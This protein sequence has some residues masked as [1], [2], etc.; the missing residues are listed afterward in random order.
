MFRK[1]NCLAGSWP[2]SLQGLNLCD[3]DLRFFQ[4]IPFTHVA[5]GA[6]SR[7]EVGTLATFLKHPKRDRLQGFSVKNLV[8]PRLSSLVLPS[9]TQLELHSCGL[10]ADD[11]IALCSNFTHLT[12]LDLSANPFPD[13]ALAKISN[14]KDL[15]ALNLS[16]CEKLGDACLPYISHNKLRVL[17]LAGVKL[18]SDAGLLNLKQIASL[19]ALNLSN[20]PRITDA[21]IL[22]LGDLEFL[23]VLDVSLT[24]ITPLPLLSRLSS[25]RLLC[26]LRCPALSYPTALDHLPR[27]TRTV[28]EQHVFGDHNPWLKTLVGE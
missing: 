5:L 10:Q 22:S 28:M 9:L 14:C 12:S 2:T 24:A 17:S 25:L 7:V 21:G 8:P 18:L 19:E 20:L 15:V 4:P 23:Q 11:V 16:G 6:K 1:V 26:V 3:S 13:H 27:G